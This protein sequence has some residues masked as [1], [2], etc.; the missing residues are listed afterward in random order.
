MYHRR[1]DAA[2]VALES[3]IKDLPSMI[4]RTTSVGSQVIPC[5]RISLGGNLFIK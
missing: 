2:T 5:P 3:F 4:S 1:N